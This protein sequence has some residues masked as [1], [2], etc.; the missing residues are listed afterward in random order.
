MAERR[1][2]CRDLAPH[3]PAAALADGL[4]E[5]RGLILAAVGGVLDAAAVR[6]ENKVV[7]RQVDGILPALAL[8][9]DAACRL[10]AVPDV[11]LHIDDLRVVLEVHT[12]LLQIMHHR[13]DH[14][15]VLIVAREAQSRKIGQAADMMDEAL[16]I[17]LH[18]QRGVPVFKG[19][20]RAPVEPE[21][22]IEHLVVEYLVDALV[23]ELLIRREEQLHDLHCG[24]VGQAELLVG[25]GVLPLLLRGTAERVV[26]IGLVEPVILIQHAHAL[27]LNGRDGAE[28]VPH[29]LEMVVH[30]AAAA[31][32]IADVGI[33]IA[34][35]RAAGDRVLLQNMDP[36]TGHLTVSDKV[37]GSRQ[38]GKAGTDEICGFFVNALRLLRAGK[39]FIITT[40]IIHAQFLRSFYRICSLIIR[41]PSFPHN[42]QK[43][44]RAAISGTA[45]KLSYFWARRAFCRNVTEAAADT[46]FSPS[47]AGRHNPRRTSRHRN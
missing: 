47:R 18:L 31:H 40:G 20:H 15:L 29:A 6:D 14:G 41:C 42:R 27:R 34:V 24:L 10:A 28:Q 17:Q 37:A 25:M 4:V 38:S 3:I 32:D 19:E 16:K 1:I 21:V 44:R 45:E 5:G 33:L 23:V 2:L 11:K 7:V 22:R 43:F 46:R 39:R 36:L 12:V 13:Q 30:L 9:N 8:Q 26:R 35:T